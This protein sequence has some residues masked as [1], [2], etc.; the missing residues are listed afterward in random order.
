[1]PTHTA[2]VAHSGNVFR[3]TLENVVQNILKRGFITRKPNIGVV[4]SQ[5]KSSGTFEQEPLAAVML[6]SVVPNAELHFVDCLPGP[7]MYEEVLEVNSIVDNR[8]RNPKR[9][10]R[11]NEF[12][13]RE[14]VNSTSE[15]E[16]EVYCASPESSDASSSSDDGSVHIQS[17]SSSRSTKVCSN[18][19]PSFIVITPP[20]PNTTYTAEGE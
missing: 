6:N 19:M 8:R 20:I 5:P 2:G 4:D 13:M 9:K 16:V 7:P 12:V 1:M 11:P 15:D 14:Q 10:G 18:L 17:K 3:Q